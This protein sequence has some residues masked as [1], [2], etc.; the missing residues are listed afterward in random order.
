MQHTGAQRGPGRTTTA[1]VALIGLV[2]GA[3]WAA[4]PASAAEGAPDSVAHRGDKEHHPDNSLEGIAS[5]FDKGADWVEID[6]HYNIDGDTFFLAHDNLCSGPGGTALIDT[7]SYQRVVERCAL[8]TLDDVFAQFTSQ[9]RRSF[10][11]EFKATGLTA[12]TGGTRLAQKLHDQGLAQASWISSFSDTALSAAQAQ[13]TG[14]Q[15]MRVRLWTGSGTITRRWIDRTA[16]LGFDAINVNVDALS[17]ERIDDARS[18]DLLI[19][20]WAWPDALERHNQTAV[21]L[22]VDMFMTD[23]LDDLHARLG[24]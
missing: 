2:L 17:E 24:R 12:R 11:Y 8:P 21:D 14:V 15:L 4:G 20:A 1:L 7:S 18:Q 22:G 10:V 23:R 3:L 6:L 13:G 19:S 5:A 9:G 16:A